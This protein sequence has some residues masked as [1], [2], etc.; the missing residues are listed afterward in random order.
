[1]AKSIMVCIAEI[2]NDGKW[3]SIIE[4]RNAIYIREKRT[5]LDTGISARLRD[6]RNQ[7]G[8]K[9]DCRIREGSKHTTEYRIT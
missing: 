4:I 7:Y 5:C 1:M 3:R 2:M 8:L 9:V 6:L